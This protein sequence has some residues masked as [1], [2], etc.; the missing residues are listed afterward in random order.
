MIVRQPFRK[1]S[2]AA[3][4][5]TTARRKCINDFT[6]FH[7]RCPIADTLLRLR[8]RHDWQR[9]RHCGDR[10]D[11]HSPYRDYL[12]L[13]STLLRVPPLSEGIGIWA[14]Q[15]YHCR[16]E[17]K[18]TQVIYLRVIPCPARSLWW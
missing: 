15:L 2:I 4:V 17:G 10:S 14:K 11:S 5:Q 7:G 6:T 12:F 9:K 3:K 18:P 8:K 1:G 16:S 13:H